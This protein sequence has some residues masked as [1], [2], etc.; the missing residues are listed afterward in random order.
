MEM[1]MLIVNSLLRDIAGDAEM[2]VLLSILESQGKS[3]RAYKRA[4]RW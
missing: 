4:A 3:R 2:T 1:P